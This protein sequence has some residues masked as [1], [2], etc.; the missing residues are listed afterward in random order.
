VYYWKRQNLQIVIA[1]DNVN[2]TMLTEYFKTCLTDDE[3]RMYL[4]KDFPEYYVWN[5]QSKKWAKRKKRFVTGRI[6]IG[7]ELNI[8]LNE[9]FIPF[10]KFHLYIFFP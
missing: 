7:N 3:T 8:S 5:S 4:Y 6:A 1:S 9:V 2:K 10:F